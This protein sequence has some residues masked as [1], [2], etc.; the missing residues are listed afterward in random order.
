MASASSIYLKFA[1]DISSSI[2]ARISYA[3]QV[4]AAI[5]NY[6]VVGADARN[7]AICLAYG[8][9]KQV[10]VNSECLYV[11]ALYHPD[12]TRPQLEKP[13]KYRYAAEE[14]PLF[15]GMD[16]DEGKP[17]WLGEIFA[18]LSSAR[19]MGITR[20]DSVGRIAYGDTVFIKCGISPHK[21]HAMLLMAWMENW[22]RNGNGKETFLRAECPVAGTEHIVVCSQDID[23]YPTNKSSTILRVLKN[24]AIAALQSRSWPFFSSSLGL[25]AKASRGE[26]IGEYLPEMMDEM[27]K[28]DVGSTLFVVSRQGHRRDPNYTLQELAPHLSEVRKRGFSVDLHGSYTSVIGGP[29]L[30]QESLSLQNVMGTKTLGNRQ[31]WLRFDRHKDLFRAIEDAGL[32]FDSS[33][34]FSNRVGFRN[35]ASFA[36]PPYDFERERPHQFLEIPLVLMDVGLEAA[37]R[38][39]GRNPQELADEVLNQ[40]RK[41]GWGGISVLWHNPIEPL[42]VPKEINDVFWNCAPEPS[43][44]KERWMSAH[45]FVERCW[46]RYENAGLLEMN[47]P[48]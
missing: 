42:H 35:G 4:F 9:K 23:F 41:W 1:D 22:L 3:L 27:E 30:R 28:R 12:V 10:G 20:R 32:V 14:L 6:R 46:A 29:T 13:V 44:P 24:I 48:S 7:G 2:R 26:R 33:V 39:E 11:P 47:I 36:F 18:W 37:S 21:P 40:S 34:G 16:G 15:Y 31:H 8:G 19:E 38:I 17:D 45:Q 5:Y 25:L 43:N